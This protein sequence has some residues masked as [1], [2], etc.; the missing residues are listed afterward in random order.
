MLTRVPG[1]EVGACKYEVQFTQAHIPWGLTGSIVWPAQPLLRLELRYPCMCHRICPSL[2]CLGLGASSGLLPFVPESRGGMTMGPGPRVPPTPALAAG[3]WAVS[4][5]YLGPEEQRSRYHGPSKLLIPVAQPPPPKSGGGTS[6]A[7]GAD[8]GRT[9]PWKE[10]GLCQPAVWDC[11]PQGSAASHSLRQQE[12]QAQ[13]WSL[14]KLQVAP[15][16]PPLAPV[17]PLPCCLTPSRSSGGC[18]LL[19]AFSFFS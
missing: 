8:L 14:H 18:L 6:G 2:F 15:A 5:S 10:G 4:P 13:G 3:S 19:Q 7:P 11:W 1:W 12:E 9:G 17:S 16:H